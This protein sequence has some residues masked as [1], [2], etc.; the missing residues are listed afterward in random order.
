[1]FV[2]NAFGILAYSRLFSFSF[3]YITMATSRISPWKTAFAMKNNIKCMYLHLGN[4]IM[5][6]VHV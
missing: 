2:E 5:N 3:W 1:M 6:D 4:F